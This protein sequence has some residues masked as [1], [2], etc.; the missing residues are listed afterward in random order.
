[1]TGEAA[2]ALALLERWDNTAAPDARGALLF[3]SW[4][5]HY[6][7]GIPDSVRFARTWSAADP[8][9]TPSGLGDPGRAAASFATV[10]PAMRERFGGW[11]VPWGEVHRVRRGSV[12]VPVGG[13]SGAAGCFRT[14]SFGRAH[15]G[16]RIAN[17]GD[18]WVLAVEFG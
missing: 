17:V 7:Q 16:K 9:H 12:D 14:I 1:P 3:E 2:E 11:D 6:A 13:C 15:D 8:V 18:A 4:W 10:L 5:N